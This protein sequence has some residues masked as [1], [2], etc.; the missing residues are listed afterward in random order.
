MYAIAPPSTP[1]DTEAET[2]VEDTAEP[3]LQLARTFSLTR[4]F[5]ALSTNINPFLAQD[6]HLDPKSPDFE[7][8]SWVKA[9][10]HT[11]SKDPS[12]H[13]R[14]TAGV[15]WRNLSVHGFSD[16]TE[17]QKDV[18]NVVWRSPLAALNW[19]AKRKQ[20]VKIISDFDGLVKSG[21]LLL[22]LG[23]PGSGVSTL[24]K[25][26]AGHTHG[27]HLDDSS[28]FNYQGIPW[29][30][31]HRNFRGEVIYQAETD[32]HF[33]QLTVGDTLL[34]AALARTPQHIIANISRHVYAEHMRDAVMAM[35]GI[36]NTLNTKVGDDFVRGVSGGERKREF[37][38]VLLL[39]EGR[40]IF[41]GPTSE[42]T[43]YFTAMGFEC[44]PRQT[45]ADFLTSLTNPDERIVRPGFE[46]KVPR[47]PDE[48]ADE[49]RMSQHRS[50]LLSDIAA[51]EI[52]YPLDGKQVETLKGIRRAQKAKFTS[53]KSPFT[54]SIPMQIHLCIGRGVKRLLG[55]KTFFVVTIAVNFVMSLVL[56]SVY[57]DLP[58]TADAMNRRASVIFFAILFNGLSSALEI[59]ALYVQRP[60]V[61]KHARYALYRPLSESVSSIICDLPSKIIST[62]AFNIPLYFMVHLRRD[63]SA[64]FIFLL[65]GFTTTMTMSMILRTI[66]QSSKTVHQALVPAA[67]FIIGLVIYAGFVLPIRSMKGWL[68]WI[69]YVNPIAYAY[70]SLVANEF[71]GRSFGCQTMIPSGP[72]YE[73]IEPMQR[74]CSVA[75]ALPGRDFIDGDF[76]MG[77]VYKYHYSHLW[78]N[79]GILIAFIIFFT[80]T[81]LFAAEYFSS[82]A[83]KGEVL[84]FRK[85]KKSRH[86][87][88]SDEE[89]VKSEFQPAQVVN[90]GTDHVPTEKPPSSSTF[91]WRN[92]CY[93][94]KV[95]GETRRIL[96]DVNGWVQPGKLTAL[97]GATGAG[98]TT[99]LDV[100]ADRVTMGVITGDILV[101]GLPR[102]KSFQRTTGYVQQQDIHLET[103]TVREALRFSAALRQPSSVC[104]QDKIDYVEEVI[105]LLE[106]G[107]YADAVIGVS[108][109]GLNVEQRKR[110]SIGV[111]L[112]A[113][114]EALIFL[115]EPTS[116]LDSQT[117]WAIVSLLKKLANHG[118]AIL[119][120]I[121]QPSGI[122]FQQ[123]DRLLLLAKGG[124]TVYFG[125]I[126][127]NA[128]ALTGYF[129]RH[130]AVQCRPE[131]NPAEWMLHVIGAAPGAHT[132][133]D[134][135]ETWKASSEFHGVQKEL[136]S[137]AQSRHV[138]SE[139]DTQDTSYAA[140]VSQQFLACTQRVAQQYW[141]TPTYIYSKLSLC[142]ITS[143]FI[144][145]SFQNSPLSLQGL[146]NQLFS[147]FMLLVIFAF[148]IYQTMPGFVTQRTLYEGRERSS[149][150]YAWYNLILAN[151]VI[152]MAWNSVASLAIYFPFY[153]LVGMYDNGRITDTQHERGA[154]MFLL[155]WAFMVYEGT[156][157][158]MCVA[159]APTAEVGATLGLFLFMM[160]LV[161]CGVLVPYS[162]LPGFWTFMYRVSPLT[163]LIGA[164]ISNGVGKQELT[165]SEIEF[166][167][168]QTPENL[169]CGEYV[170]QFV[171][172]V[173]GALS[174]P[175]SN[176][177]CLYCPIA[178]TDTYLTT[179]SI[180]YSERWRNFGL[181][182][183]FIV[184]DVIAALAAYWLIR[185]PKKGTRLLFWKK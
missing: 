149:K 48:F 155:T 130:D 61:E 161:F 41:F 5:S 134:W 49:W 107:P 182:W 71:S 98:K 108:G 46:N 38:K 85:V 1:Q 78:R 104:M 169:T 30:L 165:C 97:M 45:T 21:E 9:L 185:V 33:P 95:K 141:R 166:L 140:S 100:L 90:D 103:S 89:A 158:H 101:N 127:E 66:A 183:A 109:K 81:Y 137:L 94:V 10:L 145:L 131:E 170:G 15:S 143:L 52:Q 180:R 73:D 25:T 174:N 44:P 175:G 47:S 132:D 84:V 176:Q 123:F 29:D 146:Q 39:Y 125:D 122:I 24:L 54:I 167:Q 8:E 99:L 83:S 79:Y 72:G 63:A 96:S 150:T 26:I 129:E 12:K 133:R 75:G 53:D 86:P 70:E 35:F 76:F 87:K 128:T 11:F 58:S 164:M 184:F 121:H 168:F 111:E 179:M 40:Q 68:R 124:R 110:L 16:P 55:D 147:I 36:S 157:A 17:F 92:V 126:G 14:Y 3:V 119:C 50:S 67:I 23:R 177:T 13:P 82:E 142:F 6:S 80:F 102:G 18:F 7:P 173:G 65:F 106:M 152:E 154:F 20:K 144:G 178:S 139:A 113:K 159:G 34:F 118:L 64:F 181:L 151:T 115:D 57:F 62:L 93:D 37:D 19:F 114:P 51:F 112:V 32:I 117:A 22:V 162:S 56:G 77:T 160:A 105:S 88:T 2:A 28:E 60:I 153:F 27:L 69:N 42:A 135:V 171:Q 148:L 120:T 136:D 116:G 43:Q 156:F 163:Y 4:T 91:C 31:M 172:A 59:L 74:T 138:T